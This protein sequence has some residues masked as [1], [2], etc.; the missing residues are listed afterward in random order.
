MVFSADEDARRRR[1]FSS[2]HRPLAEVQFGIIVSQIGRQ[3]KKLSRGPRFDNFSKCVYNPTR[4]DAGVAQS[5]EHLTCN[6]T[7][8]GSIPTASSVK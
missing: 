5:A 6:E 2:A 4:F 8:V 1:A 7:V 3:G